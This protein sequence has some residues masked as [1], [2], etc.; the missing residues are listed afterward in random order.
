MY[1]ALKINFVQNHCH[2]GSNESSWPETFTNAFFFL[3]TFEIVDLKGGSKKHFFS[4]PTSMFIMGCEIGA[5][6]HMIF[7]RFLK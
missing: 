5:L 1:L 2:G 7:F 4:K 3:I 6:V